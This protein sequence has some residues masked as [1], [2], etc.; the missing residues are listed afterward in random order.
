[1]KA[2][3]AFAFADYDFCIDVDGR[4]NPSFQLFDETGYDAGSFR[5][6]MPKKAVY[7]LAARCYNKA[8][9]D[10]TCFG[11]RIRMSTELEII[12]KAILDFQ[13]VQVAMDLAREE[14]AEKTYKYLLDTY[15]GLKALLT[16]AGV[17]LTE[18]DRLKK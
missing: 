2:S 8:N 11:R 5:A 4:G 1:M 3:V 14:K 6:W 18:I 17:N 7:I 16:T 15:I 10:C 12:Q 13:R 9:S